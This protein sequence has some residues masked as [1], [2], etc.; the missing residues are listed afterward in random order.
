MGRAQVI[1]ATGIFDK[2]NIADGYF[3]EANKSTEELLSAPVKS[4]RQRD[5]NVGTGIVLKGKGNTIEFVIKRVKEI[6]S[7]MDAYKF[8]N[9]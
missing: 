8:Y 7:M 2:E 4:Y 6:L 5:F 9:N 1:T 3:V